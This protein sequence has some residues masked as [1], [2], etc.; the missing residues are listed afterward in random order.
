MNYE[1]LYFKENK[2]AQ[3]Y[4]TDHE[5]NFNWERGKMKPSK[6]KNPCLIVL[7]YRFQDIMLAQKSPK[8][9]Y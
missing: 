8:N 7:I 2:A 5:Y 3:Y 9:D 4:F 6:V 1:R